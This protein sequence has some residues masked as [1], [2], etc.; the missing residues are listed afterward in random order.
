MAV[1]SGFDMGGAYVI[2]RVGNCV[3]CKLPTRERVSP[4]GDRDADPRGVCG[5]RAVVH[6]QAAEF[7]YVAPSPTAIACYRCLY[8]K[9]SESYRRVF[10]ALVKSHGWV[11]LESLTIAQLEAMPTISQGHFDNLK[12]DTGVRR[13]WLTR[14]T[15]EDGHTGSRRNDEVMFRGNW[16]A[17]D[18]AG[19]PVLECA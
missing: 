1:E 10:A 6:V 3:L 14:M 2:E 16:V 8:E 11:K 7:G 12:V 4:N 18:V 9:G 19:R 17:C 13:V 5:L 15:A